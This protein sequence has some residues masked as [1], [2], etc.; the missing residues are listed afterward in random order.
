MKADK[1]TPKRIPVGP[2]VAGSEKPVAVTLKPP[3]ERVRSS[4]PGVRTSVLIGLAV[5]LA[6]GFALRT[7]AQESKVSLITPQGIALESAPKHEPVARLTEARGVDALFVCLGIVYLCGAAL[8]TFAVMK[9]AS[10][11]NR[12]ACTATRDWMRGQGLASGHS[13]RNSVTET[14]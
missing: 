14:R 5:L 3:H 13:N 8:F 9:T 1:H 10:E 4:G 7:P 11:S 2:F 12:M 6:C